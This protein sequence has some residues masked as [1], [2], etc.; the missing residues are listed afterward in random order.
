M[1][2]TVLVTGANG[3]V[4]YAL[5]LALQAAGY[6]V[7][8]GLRGGGSD[9]RFVP[10]GLQAVP[11]DVLDLE[12]IRAAMRGVSG[13]FHVAGAYSF[14]PE[15][16]RLVHEV[17]V[18]G[19]S[20]VLRIA[21]EL[22]PR[23]VVLTSS[24]VTVGASQAGELRD[25]THWVAS[26]Q[27]PYIQAKTMAEK[28]AVERSKLT[29]LDLIR[30]LPVAILGPGFVRHTPS[31]RVLAQAL[32]GQLPFSLP[33][34]FSFVDVRDVAAAHLAAF[35]RPAANGRYLVAGDTCSMSELFGTMA[36][37]RPRARLPKRTLP[38]FLL[39]A[40]PSFD[41]LLAKRTGSPRFVT[42]EFLAEYAGR[43]QLVSAARATRELGF[44][45]RPLSDTVSDT[46]D[47][48]ELSFEASASV[49][50]PA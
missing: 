32:R 15:D 17:N 18:D 21:A 46:L 36:K 20:N 2:E 13:V 41:W 14:A 38:K 9:A 26:S 48:L 1:S 4:G 3:H 16:A 40:S 27:V 34:D 5:C 50:R 44:T 30:V 42:R 22:R 31:T 29:G 45:P 19:T 25:E 24:A 10:R 47:W 8:A 28:L 23:R 11:L 6:C 7:R 39:R 49:H 33:L 37:Q 43:P 12:S 35:Q